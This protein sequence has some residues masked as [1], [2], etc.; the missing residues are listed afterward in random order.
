MPIYEYVC[1]NCGQKFEMRRGF[2]Q[3]DDPATCPE[4]GDQRVRRLLSTFV[5]FSS[6]EGGTRTAV[7]GASGCSACA[8][9]S[10]AGCGIARG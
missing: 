5:A 9:T 1:V 8:A 2:G 6:S 7:A 4:C 10:C 3:A